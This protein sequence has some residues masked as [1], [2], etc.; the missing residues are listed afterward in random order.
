MFDNFFRVFKFGWQEVSRNMGISI[1][2]IFIIFIALCL[3]GGTFL[4]RGMSENLISTL[5]NK[6]DISVYFKDEAKEEDILVVK[7]QIEDF[8]GIKEVEYI[9]KEKALESFKETQKNNQVLMESLAEVGGNPLPSS[10]NIKAT[11]VFSYES[12][13]NFLSSGEY[14]DLIE[15]INWS[16][17]QTIIERL[18]SISN[19][20]K[21]GGL[22]TSLIL[23]LIA[24]A[25]TFNTI[26]LAIYSKREEIETMKLI[27]ATNWFIRGPFVVQ[28]LITGLVAGLV[29]FLFFYG[30][31][32]G[33]SP[34]SLG[35][36]GELGLFN[37]F[38][39]NILLFL[40]LQVGGGVI[41]STFASLVAIQRYLKV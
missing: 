4:L 36:F 29:A 13:A 21:I 27:G 38:E 19:A 7:K 34:Q 15:K 33:L 23:V 16:E 30:I 12:L 17:T 41:I 18:F 5:E 6:A 22:A 10:L 37:F 28:G 31:E 20:I 39:E 35:I 2:T 8:P 32:A 3:V 24:I 40:L 25:V 11:E 14:K 1:G 26:R 9:S